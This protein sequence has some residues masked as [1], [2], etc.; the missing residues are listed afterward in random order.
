MTASSQTQTVLRP[1]SELQQQQELQRGHALDPARSVWV[2]ASAGSGKT[3]LLTERV[4][5]LLLQN[6]IENCP[7]LPNILCLTYTKAAAAEMQNRI[8]KHLGQWAILPEAELQNKLES[9]FQI[10]TNN[11]ILKKARRLFA[12]VLERPDCIRIMTM[13]AFCQMILNRFPH[14]AGLAPHFTLLEGE[15][16]KDFQQQ[17]LRYCFADIRKNPILTAALNT[18]GETQSSSRTSDMLQGVFQ[19]AAKWA[20]HFEVFPELTLFANDLQK[21]LGLTSVTT[22][23]LFLSSNCNEPALPEQAMLQAAEY[24]QVGTQNDKDRS[25][26]IRVW[27]TDKESRAK[28]F[29]DYANIYLTDK[30]EIR[31]SL[32]TKEVSKKYPEIVDIMSREASRIDAV[33]QQRNAL[34]FYHQ[35]CAFYELS[36]HMWHLLKDMKQ[37]HA[38]LTYDDL[39]LT[40]RDLLSNS[41][42][43]P[44]ILYK[45]DG[46]IDHILIDEAQDTSP[47]QWDIVF[48]LLDEILS[49]VGARSDA[50]RTIF[51]VGDEKQSIYSFQGANHRHYLD[52]K[53][54]LFARFENLPNRMQPVERIQSY[55]STSAVL[56]FVDAVFQQDSVRQ[57]VSAESIRHFA[58]R[59]AQG[60]VELWPTIKTE[61]AELPAAW[62]PPMQRD[63]S[64]HAYIQLAVQIANQISVWLSQGWHIKTRA[65]HGADALR[66]IK[67]DD[68]IILLQYRSHLL[69]P[70]IRALKDRNI[71]V[72]GIDRMRLHEQAAIQDVLTLCRFLLLPN[73]DL[74]LAELLRGPFIR[75]SD[76]QLFE[77][78]HGRSGSLW[79]AL[80]SIPHYSTICD[81]LK[82]FLG[83]VDTISSF[84]IV[85]QIYATPCPGH[86]S[87][88]KAALI[89][90]L[91]IDAID[92]LEQLL[93]A[94]RNFDSQNPL[95]LQLFVRAIAEDDSEIKREQSDANGQVRIMTTHG[96][97]GLEAPIVIMP[98]LMR[99]PY[100]QRR[101]DA[102]LWDEQGITYA[103][104]PVAKW[105]PLIKHVK[106]YH[107]TVREEEHRRLLYVAL[108]RAAD[109]LIL[110]SAVKNKLPNNSPWQVHTQDAMQRL[111][112]KVVESAIGTLYR[113][114]DDTTLAP[115]KNLAPVE[116]PKTIDTPAWLYQPLQNLEKET[117]YNPS[118]LVKPDEAQLSPILSSS[119]AP[120]SSFARGRLLHRL[121][122]LLPALPDDARE[123]AAARF[124]ERNAG[125]DAAANARDVREVMAVL[126]HPHFAKV[127]SRDAMAEMPIIGTLNG[128]HFS[129]QIDRMLV[130]QDEVLVIDFKTNRPPPKTIEQVDETY[131][132]QMACYAGLL[133]QIYPGKAIRTALLWTHTVTLME[134]NSAA[135][136][137]GKQILDRL[138]KS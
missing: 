67:P 135:L 98:D 137:R 54:K 75:I 123:T 19:N 126:H 21:R 138:P 119:S 131:L 89:H 116:T 111:N 76:L 95:S 70:I 78:A 47:Q 23:A 106:T 129:G 80:Q 13:H 132:A 3:T 96:A 29:D 105:I 120:S 20:G 130:T 32:F 5:R 102:L 42:V 25:G 46:G 79:A 133:E 64:K 37:R 52:V 114:G 134:L 113:Y 31:K 104:T 36:K 12:Q 27:I 58:H 87:G 33:V 125:Q 82:I 43:A 53:Q 128:K 39:I 63:D 48:G 15:A 6:R 1:V 69:A 97:K 136:Q 85:S 122:Q 30:Q 101:T 50:N 57:G 9:T 73:D 117:I 38:Q 68:I 94:A 91:G 4:L 11:E 65:E 74:T 84:A 16:E 110:C 17:V 26:A 35:Q 61:P 72:A 51:V 49:G 41:D 77:I 112:A 34:L 22:V 71:P 18:L 124:L 10:K 40:T 14:E 55:R 59:S 8:H 127:F 45:L 7:R 44:W 83:V 92:P 100:K 60:F 28:N 115:P 109:V 88:G 66:P 24:L 107:E 90:R 93:S 99:D 2:S 86:I 103:A 118:S 81:Y 108:T 56:S 121:L 62:H